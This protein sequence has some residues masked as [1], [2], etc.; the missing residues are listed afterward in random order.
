LPSICRAAKTEPRSERLQQTANLVGAGIDSYLRSGTERLAQVAALPELREDLATNR[1]AAAP[2][3]ETVVR[4]LEDWFFMSRVCVGGVMLVGDSEEVLWSEPA[5]LRTTPLSRA[6]VQVLDDAK[7]GGGALVSSGVPPSAVVSSP[8]VT[9]VQPIFGKDGRA[10]AHLVGF[11]DLMWAAFLD[12][13]NVTA[14]ADDRF[15]VTDQK[16]QV[17]ASTGDHALLTLWWPPEAVENSVLAATRLARAHWQVRA[18]QPKET[19]LAGVREWQYRLLGIGSALLLLVVLMGGPFI[20]SF[21]DAITRL[22]HSAEVM[23]AGDLT[24]PVR[25]APRSDELGT[26]A[27]TF[28]RMRSELRQSQDALRARLIE[29][30]ELLRLKEEFLANTSHELRTPLNVILGYNDMVADLGRNPEL[31]GPIRGI[32]AQANH[33]LNL[34]EDPMTLSGVNSGKLSVHVAPVSL[35]EL[36]ERLATLARRLTANRAITLAF[37]LDSTVATIETDGHRLEQILSNLVTNACKFT[38]RGRISLRAVRVPD[39]DLLEFTISDTGIGIP[40]RELPFIFDEFRQVDGS[41]SRRHGGLGLGLAVT[42]KLLTLLGGQI[43]V[44]S[45]EGEGASFCVRIPLRGGAA[46]T[47]D[48]AARHPERAHEPV[49]SEAGQLFGQADPRSEA[50]RTLIPSPAGRG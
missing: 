13:L 14:R 5:T 1:P 38:E 39:T 43:S 48:P 4:A 37:D 46:G 31:E 24:Q 47:A 29:R 44:R 49:A 33:L 28:D 22:N 45:V 32:R 40:A 10:I 17:L 12:V 3:P 23:A 19:A 50:G 36:G 15:V 7:R 2:L 34:I 26:L 11:V 21:R 25:T 18:G 27:E 6:Q 9:L 35:A 20:R 41:M 42:H 8:H 30:D 16:G